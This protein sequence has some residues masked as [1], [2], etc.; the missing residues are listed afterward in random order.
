MVDWK[1]PE[2]TD[3]WI[4][5]DWNSGSFAAAL[6]GEILTGPLFKSVVESGRTGSSGLVVRW[7]PADADGS[8][9]YK[10]G[11][12]DLEE[13]RKDPLLFSGDSETENAP[14]S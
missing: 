2:S 4:S 11:E 13:A 3:V 5:F 1:T 8:W 6:F 12:D 9:L 14:E 10:V 7:C